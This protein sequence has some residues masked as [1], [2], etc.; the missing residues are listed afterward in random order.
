MGGDADDDVRRRRRRLSRAAAVRASVRPLDD[1]G[2]DGDGSVVAKR[3][4]RDG[5]G[6]IARRDDADA[7]R[8]ARG[9]GTT[10][11]RELPGA[12]GGLEEATLAVM[13]GVSLGDVCAR[14]G[15]ETMV[16]TRADGT[17]TVD[18]EARAR[19]TEAAL[20]AALAEKVVVLARYEGKIGGGRTMSEGDGSVQNAFQRAVFARK[21]H[22]RVVATVREEVRARAESDLRMARRDAQEKRMLE[23]RDS[24]K[25]KMEAQREAPHKP[26]FLLETAKQ[27]QARLRKMAMVEAAAGETGAHTTA[28]LDAWTTPQNLQ[29]EEVPDPND[30]SIVGTVKTCFYMVQSHPRPIQKILDYLFGY[31]PSVDGEDLEEIAAY[32]KGLPVPRTK[33]PKEIAYVYAA[34]LDKILGERDKMALKMLIKD[35]K[36]EWSSHIKAGFD[37]MKQLES[38]PLDSAED[39]RTQNRDSWLRAMFPTYDWP[40]RTEKNY[41]FM[42]TWRNNHSGASR[43]FSSKPIP[44]AVARANLAKESALTGENDVKSVD[45]GRHRVR[46][47]KDGVPIV[48]PEGFFPKTETMQSKRT[49]AARWRVAAEEA[50]KKLRARREM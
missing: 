48:A 2:V 27:E 20:D 25:L 4:E 26:W 41:K 5:R 34:N 1:A 18:E 30:D 43:G 40:T 10:F 29:T 9:N 15:V 28:A 32:A 17:A 6:G 49:E 19:T 42:E 44:L 11:V 35:V 45:M 22:E 3:E 46:Y 14:T 24:I 7:P 39:I 47:S 33:R 31:S 12:S 38:T 23:H 16:R 13:R 50:D 36:D 21:L 37:A 8:G